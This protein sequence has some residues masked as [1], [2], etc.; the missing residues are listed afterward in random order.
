MPE[1]ERRLHSSSGKTS[2]YRL[3]LFLVSLLPAFVLIPHILQTWVSVPYWD[4]WY[5]PGHQLLSLAKGQLTIH[6]MFSQHNESRPFI[7]RLILLP[8]DWFGW[9]VRKAMSVIF[10]I[11][12]FTAFLLHRLVRKMEGVSAKGALLL[13]L[14]INGIVFWP[15]PQVWN[16]ENTFM[17]AC[18]PLLLLCALNVNLADV[19]FRRKVMVNSLL[20]AIATYSWSNGM[21]LWLFALPLQSSVFRLQIL[22]GTAEKKEV[23][24]YLFYAAACVASM[25]YYFHD[26]N[27][28]RVSISILPVID[29]FLVW[30]GGFFG[31]Y[32]LARVIGACAI[33]TY[34][35]LLWV[36]SRI[37]PE[38]RNASGGYPWLVLGFYAIASGVM[39]SLG[40]VKMGVLGAMSPRYAAVSG[41]LYIAI[42]GLGY[43]AWS[44]AGE[45]GWRSKESRVLRAAAI[46]MAVLMLPMI[47]IGY[48]HGI[49]LMDEVKTIRLTALAAWQWS[50][51]MPHS[52]GMTV[53]TPQEDDVLRVGGELEKYHILKI[54]RWEPELTANWSYTATAT[55]DRNGVLEVCRINPKL[56]RLQLQGWCRLPDRN[57]AADYVLF[58]VC[59]KSGTPKPY[60]VLPGGA[61]PR[62][63]IAVSTGSKAMF[64]SGFAQELPAETL[65]DGEVTVAAW[66]V[67]MNRRTISPLAHTFT[68][69]V[70]HP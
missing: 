58:T 60:L 52:A 18:P 22:P 68:L 42:V 70:N 61:M 69:Q 17:M 44:A 50:K 6:E 21:V 41:F 31:S 10:V 2:R 11:L 56:N 13:S 27:H 46:V 40:R 47:T 45:A 67:D 19:S 1:P 62:R 15:I 26:L 55:D 49:A 64:N 29:Y 23:R 4:D 36:Y 34:I 43:L 16:M 63:D 30:L 39:A 65:P 53:L 48:V 3:A 37:V 54:K 32:K 12:C 51:I 59:E 14:V 38:K 66:A 9:D 24:W 5:T 25:G 8:M 33:V 20:A 35:V 7:P 28:E 57:A